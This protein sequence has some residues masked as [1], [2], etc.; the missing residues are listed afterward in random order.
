M[1]NEAFYVSFICVTW[2]FRIFRKKKLI[3][4]PNHLLLL[5]FFFFAN[6]NSSHHFHYTMKNRSVTLLIFVVY[7]K[8]R[9][10]LVGMTWN[11]VM[12]WHALIIKIQRH[13]VSLY[14]HSLK[15]KR[16]STKAIKIMWVGEFVGEKGP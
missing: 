16:F 2:I 9:L 7:E 4:K 3:S 12:I 5:P 13:F 15:P 14:I 10:A 1:S 6:F 8:A 11:V